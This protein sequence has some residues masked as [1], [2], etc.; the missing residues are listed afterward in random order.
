[1][2]EFEEVK[3]QDW[4]R[5]NRSAKL[6]EILQRPFAGFINDSGKDRIL[7]LIAAQGEYETVDLTNKLV[8]WTDASHLKQYGTGI[9]FVW[10]ERH[11]D[12]KWRSKQYFVEG[13]FGSFEGEQFAISQAIKFAVQF[14]RESALRPPEEDARIS[15]VYIYSDAVENLKWIRDFHE[16]DLSKQGRFSRLVEMARL[17]ERAEEPVKEMGVR[18]ELH[19]VKGHAKIEGNQLADRLAREAA[20]GP[21]NHGKIGVLVPSIDGKIALT[22]IKRRSTKK[23]KVRK[24]HADL[25]LEVDGLEITI[26]PEIRED[27]RGQK[28]NA[29]LP[30]R[31]KM[32]RFKELMFLS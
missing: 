24:S 2:T 28:A 4:A 13:E 25:K 19:W 23:V 16:K 32:D 9:A 12:R 22:K 29:F 3:K 8:F 20:R 18:L 30:P 7:S 10:K 26:N 6:N 31:L 17:K 14:C 11:H 15:T 27:T 1:M 5:V 21:D